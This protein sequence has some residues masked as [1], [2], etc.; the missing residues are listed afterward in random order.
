VLLA[1]SKSSPATAAQMAKKLIT[2]GKADMIV[3]TSA[4]ETT[5]PVAVTC[6]KLKTPCLSTVVPW[7]AWY[8]SLGGDPL[9]PIKS[10]TYCTV[11]F[12]GLKEFQGCF[13]PMWNQIDTN[14]AVACQYPADTD[15]NAF[16]AGLEPLIE[17]SG[18]EVVDGGPYKDG[19]TD[20]SAMITK[21]K[22]HQ[23]E[24]FSNCPLPPD[25]ITFWKQ[26]ARQGWKPKLATV[27]KVLLFPAD[28]VPLGPLVNNIAT[29]SWWGPFMPNTSSLT[30]QTAQSL[31]DGYEAATGKQWVQSL[32]STYSLFEVA[33][34]AL[35]TVSDPHDRAEVASS[36][37]DI[38]YT[39]MCGALNFAN[40]PAPGVA[41]LNPVGVQWRKAA[42]GQY[43]YDMRVVDNTLNTAVPIEVE[44]KATNV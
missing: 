5:N 22:K 34:E 38:N 14:K 39:G 19:T 17:A 15:G 1:D 3:T 33:R 43:P 11:F 42:A 41:I 7:E 35:R 26:A 2:Q 31:A 29:D 30:G 16:R 37:H 18:Y 4:P 9:K 6:Q 40:G 23:A 36:L 21:F 12:F 10:I 27:A 25:F 44:L 32:G 24:L 28:L 13:A 8:G 20:F